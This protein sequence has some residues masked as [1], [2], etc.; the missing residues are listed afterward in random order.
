MARTNEL[1]LHQTKSLRTTA[2]YM[3][4]TNLPAKFGT[5]AATLVDE[6]IILSIY[7]W[8]AARFAFTFRFSI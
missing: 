7:E 2:I 6:L 5:L 1:H 3:H 8:N 4:S